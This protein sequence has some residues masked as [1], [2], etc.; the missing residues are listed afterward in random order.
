MSNFNTANIHCSTF[1]I[2]T[3]FFYNRGCVSVTHQAED[4]MSDDFLDEI[5]DEEFDDPF[6]DAAETSG[7]SART[8][9]EFEAEVERRMKVLMTKKAG[10][11]QRI[12]A[13]YWLGD[14]GAPKAIQALRKVYAKEK[15][16]KIKAAAAY[17]LGQFRALD[18]A[19]KR[20]EGESVQEALGR[21]ENAWIV[22]LLTEIA[23]E[24]KRGKSLPVSPG[25]LTR[26]QMILVVTLIG[27]IAANILM[28]GGLS[29]NFGGGDSTEFSTLSPARPV[30]THIQNSIPSIRNDLTLLMGE[31]TSAAGGGL[32]NCG[33]TFNNPQP[34]VLEEPLAAEYP[35]VNAL[36]TA[37]NE[38]QTALVTAKNNYN[39]G[40]AR[41][42]KNLIALEQQAIR[43]SS[44]SINAALPNIEG[45]L[46]NNAVAEVNQVEVE[47]QATATS[48]ALTATAVEAQKSITPMFGATDTPAP[49]AT[50]TATFT[51]TPDF[52]NYTGPLFTLIDNTRQ[53]NN[54][55][56]SHLEA[57]R[58]R[59]DTGGC[60]MPAEVV[61]ADY[62]LPPEDAAA[63]PG[64][65]DTVTQINVALALSR[66]GWDLF[67]QSC[68][69]GTIA[70]NVETG[71]AI[72]QTVE[73]ALRNGETQLSAYR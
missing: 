14:S 34:A 48:I 21:S 29:F 32:L 38:Q 16:K 60:R 73:D 3:P 41:E 37:Y 13:A 18:N 8:L 17:A 5:D 31:V 11:E 39:T 35:Q 24:D 69:N 62:V 46:V 65:Q 28:G 63:I 43:T 40:C 66:S 55:L 33:L 53:Q 72:V 4:E 19:I 68:N 9:E 61:A 67:T 49:S 1:A 45:Q 54:I 7:S 50:P 59:A 36:V 52:R 12:D 2:L 10:V 20:D 44:D 71:L 23:L 57:I 27:L 56:R 26:L 51:A 30:L 22:E 42:T 64:L 15:D 47:L 70:A 6:D 58:D 25:C